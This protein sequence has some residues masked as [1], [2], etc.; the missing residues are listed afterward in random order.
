MAARGTF[1][2]TLV[3][4]VAAAFSSGIV[5]GVNIGRSKAPPENANGTCAITEENGEKPEPD[6]GDAGVNQE[7]PEKIEYADAPDFALEDISTGENIELSMFEGSPL[8]LMI[9]TTT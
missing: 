4:L 7:K 6:S 9:S 2:T 1:I 5:I 3:I 8:L